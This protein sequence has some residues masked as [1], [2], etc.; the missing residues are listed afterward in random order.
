MKNLKDCTM[1]NEKIN[2]KYGKLYIESRCKRAFCK[3]TELSLIQFKQCL[4]FAKRIY[5]PQDKV[6]QNAISFA[7]GS[8]RDKG[9]VFKNTLQGKI[10]EFGFY[11]YF[12]ER[13]SIPSP[14]MDLWELGKWEDT[15]FMVTVNDKKY[16]ISLKSTKNY[17]N[18]LML[19]CARYDEKGHYLEGANGEKS[20][21]HDFVFLA[22]VKG[23]DS[24]KPDDYMDNKY[25]EI[26]IEISGYITINMFQEKIKHDGYI[27]KGTLIGKEPLQVDNYCFCLSELSSP[28]KKRS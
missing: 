26:E 17:G 27:P 24:I 15:D 3:N 14:Q 16:N 7:G 23:V 8:M 11:N 10:A 2:I 5:D 25:S 18:L 21:K 6:A 9:T 4:Y 12:K 1:G 19:E 22:R 13:V 20:I 28:D